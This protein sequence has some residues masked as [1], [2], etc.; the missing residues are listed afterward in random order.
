M[1]CKILGHKFCR[2]MYGYPY[3]RRL[4]HDIFR[5]KRCGTIKSKKDDK[6][7]ILA[8]PAQN[9]MMQITVKGA[10]HLPDE[11]LVELAQKYIDPR[12]DSVESLCLYYG[13]GLK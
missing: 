13:N 9:D 10:K 8:H 6:E 3:S 7:D 5:C 2:V 11:V 12:I 4:W 1:K